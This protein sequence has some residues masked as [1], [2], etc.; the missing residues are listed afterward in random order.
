MLLVLQVTV[1]VLS[2]RSGLIRIPL[3]HWISTVS[4]RFMK[5][6]P[7]PSAGIVLAMLMDV[8]FGSITLSGGYVHP[9]PVSE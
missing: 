4:F 6:C 3:R 8:A 7:Y 2:A 5:L 9:F 1:R